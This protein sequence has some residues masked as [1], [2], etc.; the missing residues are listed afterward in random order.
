[1]AIITVS[2]GTFS[3]GEGLA[4]W[5]AEKLGYRCV[6]REVVTKAAS[7]YGADEQRLYKALVE[8]P[9]LIE[10]LT[11]DRTR[12]LALIQAALCKTVKDDNI[13][14]HGHAGHL[15]LRGIPHV[16]RVRVIANMELRIRA[17]MHR[18]ELT[19][20]QAIDYIHKVDEDRA[21]WAKFLYHVDWQDPALYDVVINL[22]H[23]S[24]SAACDVVCAAAGLEEFRTTSESQRMMDDAVVSTEVRA[25]IAAD[26]SMADAQVEV[27]AHDGIVIAS[28]T[29][30]SPEALEKINHI[31]RETPGAR[32]LKSNI[33]IQTHWAMMQG[34]YLR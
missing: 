9:G 26:D 19:R 13:V 20:S 16:I 25:R 12:Y 33:R 22:D 27:T 11:L 7:E 17:A 34:R 14:Y 21:K 23:F 30:G 4:K 18:Q 10:R 6:A 8:K 2:R 1:V 3:G 28:G 5:V 24:L 31:V 29:V 15:L 32:E